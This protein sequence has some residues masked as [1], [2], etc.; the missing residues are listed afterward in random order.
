MPHLLQQG[1]E[2]ANVCRLPG[3]LVGQIV[4]LG[5]LLLLHQADLQGRKGAAFTRLLH[6]EGLQR[7]GEWQLQRPCLR[8]WL[9]R[10]VLLRLA[11]LQHRALLVEGPSEKRAMD[12]NLFGF[13]ID[14]CMRRAEKYT[15][16]KASSPA[17]HYC[18]PGALFVHMSK[19]SLL[20]SH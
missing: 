8:Q 13:H 16:V 1:I 18:L 20:A 6:Y 17:A 4:D 7:K 2:P 15:A 10:M 11:L 12:A 19:D 14:P 5:A 9:L 3:H